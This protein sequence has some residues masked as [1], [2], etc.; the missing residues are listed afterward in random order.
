MKNPTNVAAMFLA[1]VAFGCASDRKNAEPPMQPS[2]YEAPPDTT[3]EPKGLPPT[4]PG[5]G[6]PVTPDTRE[7]EAPDTLGPQAPAPPQ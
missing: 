4:A 3:A 6:N 7:P 5:E 2:S 1:V